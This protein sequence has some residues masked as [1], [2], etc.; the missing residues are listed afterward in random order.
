MLQRQLGESEHMALAWGW[1]CLLCMPYCAM[2]HGPTYSLVSCPALALLL[3]RAAGL[4]LD[5]LCLG[6]NGD[7]WL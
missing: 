2:L 1:S 4:G 3:P 5:S 7:L 6:D